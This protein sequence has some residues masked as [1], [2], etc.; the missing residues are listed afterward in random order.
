MA[1]TSLEA[2]IRHHSRLEGLSYRMVAAEVIVA[3]SGAAIMKPIIDGFKV[4]WACSSNSHTSSAVARLSRPS[5]IG[6]RSKQPNCV[7]SKEK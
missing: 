5:R 6:S 7:G 1:I 4:D 2:I 3:S